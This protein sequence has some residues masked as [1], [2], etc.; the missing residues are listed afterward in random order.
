M[1]NLL[2]SDG[3][4]EYNK[5]CTTD[6]ELRFK[7]LISKFF[8]PCFFMSHPLYSCM[9]CIMKCKVLHIRVKIKPSIVNMD[10]M[11]KYKY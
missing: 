9:K 7:G 11:D 3:N 10:N 4:F 1:F 2:H 5:K 8:I 6:C